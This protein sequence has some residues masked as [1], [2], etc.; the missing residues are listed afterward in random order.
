VALTKISDVVTE[1]YKYAQQIGGATNE[2][3]AGS[4]QIGKATSR[5]TEITQEINST[6]EE[7]ASGVQSVVRAMEK[8]REV[9]QQA[10]SSSS[11]LAA[12]AKHSSKLSHRLIEV[13][14]LFVLE[15][16]P[17]SRTNGNASKRSSLQE[18]SNSAEY[19]TELARV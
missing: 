5:L 18:D 11:Q 12:M 4:T 13:A 17:H 10:T 1:V 2:Q 15:D 7:Q 9:V 16:Q 6:I 19:E 14:D 8:M 3:S